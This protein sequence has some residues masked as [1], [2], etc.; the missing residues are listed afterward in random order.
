M[1][2][3]APEASRPQME[4]TSAAAAAADDARARERELELEESL[5][6]A[7]EVRRPP[8]PVAFLEWFSMA[9]K[10]A[11]ALLGRRRRICSALLK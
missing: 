4:K 7:Q 6:G 8:P 9:Y 3:S 5:R 2:S 1:Q 10:R 11:G